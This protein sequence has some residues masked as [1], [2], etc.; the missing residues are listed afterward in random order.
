MDYSNV[1]GRINATKPPLE[2]EKAVE[3]HLIKRMKAIR[4]QSYKWSS[5]NNRGVPDRICIFPGGVI[6]FVEVKSE[7][8]VPSKL[9]KLIHQELELLVDEVRV[10]DTKAGVD[11]FINE[12]T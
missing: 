7:G 12:Y 8:K 10:V 4:G 1:F 11:D 3:K 2:S 6:V 9:Q 5:P